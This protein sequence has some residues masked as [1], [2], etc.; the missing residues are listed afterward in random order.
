MQYAEKLFGVFS[1]L[2]GAEEFSG[3][4]V[5][6]A[7]VQRILTRHGGRIWAKAAVDA[8]AS[9]WFAL[10]LAEARPAET[11]SEQGGHKPEGREARGFTEGC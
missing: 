7:I 11:S 9:F 3:T 4:G 2:H 6:L 1:R 10:P 5:G 8:G